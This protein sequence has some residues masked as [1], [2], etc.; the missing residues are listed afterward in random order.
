MKNLAPWPAPGESRVRG[1]LS[2]DPADI[3]KYSH[4]FDPATKAIE[5]VREHIRLDQ[6]RDWLKRANEQLT[7]DR[8]ET[9]ELVRQLKSLQQQPQPPTRGR[10][11]VIPGDGE[12]LR[13][14]RAEHPGSTCRGEFL[15]TL[16]KDLEKNQ[17]NRRY[18][19]ADKWLRD[20]DKSDK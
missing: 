7:R 14:L 11:S 3:A 9:K 6:D 5:L 19:D 1:P 10:P 13:N 16:P 8:E 15:A 17:K 18:R 2:T 20:G 4:V 12:T